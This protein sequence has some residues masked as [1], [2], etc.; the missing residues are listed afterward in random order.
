MAAL[1]R[2]TEAAAAAWFAAPE[3]RK[4]EE[5][6]AYGPASGT[7]AGFARGRNREQLELRLVKGGRGR[8][9]YPALRGGDAAEPALTPLA[10]RSMATLDRVAR[11]LLAHVASDLGASPG[12]F[13]SLLDPQLPAEEGAAAAAEEEEAEAAIEAEEE[14]AAAATSKEALEAHA[15]CPPLRH[16]GFAPFQNKRAADAEPDDVSRHSGLR[17]CRYKSDA[18]GFVTLA[19]GR[20][21]ACEEH[22]DVGLLTL[23]PRASVPGLQ[24]FRQSSRRWVDLEGGQGE[25]AEETEGLLT[26]MVGDTLAAEG[27]ERVGLPFLFRCRGEAIIDTREERRRA[28]AEGRE[29]ALAELQGSSV[30]DLPTADCPAALV[31]YM[32]WRRRYRS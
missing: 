9:V 28:A 21:V 1:L 24:A 6:G 8:G 5:A 7:L 17:A 31:N 29:T 22:N 23:D 14:A 12:F 4:L 27:E 11:V 25:A 16:A 3:A 30:E 10:E 19:S 32:A 20:R 2:Q 15:G 18:P 13:A 26:V